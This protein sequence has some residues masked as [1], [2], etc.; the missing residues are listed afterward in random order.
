MLLCSQG[1]CTTLKVSWHRPWLVC[2]ATRQIRQQEHKFCDFASRLDSHTHQLVSLEETLVAAAAS[3]HA[4][5]VMKLCR[6]SFEQFSKLLKHCQ[7][8]GALEYE[9][10]GCDTYSFRLFSANT[11]YA[12]LRRHARLKS[13]S[14]GRSRRHP[15]PPSF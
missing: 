10:H 15:R 5:E 8:T 14:C 4:S 3:R 12:R 1:W 11:R 6:S 7:T 13:W 2:P 9:S